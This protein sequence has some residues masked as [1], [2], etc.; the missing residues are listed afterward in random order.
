MKSI[1]SASGVQKDFLPQILAG[2]CNGGLPNIEDDQVAQ[3]ACSLQ[4]AGQW[5]H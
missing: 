3:Q 4:T 2:L 1:L 5:E